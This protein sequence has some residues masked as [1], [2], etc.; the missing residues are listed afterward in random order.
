MLAFDYTSFQ[1]TLTP[2]HDAFALTLL[3]ALNDIVLC[4]QLSSLRFHILCFFFCCVRSCKNHFLLNFSF[5]YA[6]KFPS[7]RY[8]V[9]ALP[10]LCDVTIVPVVLVLALMLAHPVR[11]T[12]L[13]SAQPSIYWGWFWFIRW[14]CYWFD[15][16]ENLDMSRMYCNTFS[17]CFLCTAVLSVLLA[18]LVIQWVFWEFYKI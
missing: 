17:C 2:A 5:L 12:L 6:S 15:S 14:Y 11:C 8:I 3:A 18:I 7:C 1:R 13:C 4:C 16:K 10:V 9:V